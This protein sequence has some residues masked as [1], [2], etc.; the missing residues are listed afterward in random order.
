M[1]TL[2]DRQC[3]TL[4]LVETTVPKS[5]QRSV[6]SHVFLEL[7]HL[8]PRVIGIQGH[9]AQYRLKLAANAEHLPEFKTRIGANNHIGYIFAEC[10]LVKFVLAYCLKIY[11]IEILVFSSS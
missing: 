8:Q 5:R 10:F 9:F 2:K 6:I 1:I 4:F 7:R 3:H 11:G